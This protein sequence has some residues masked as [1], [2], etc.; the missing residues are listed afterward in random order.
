MKRPSPTAPAAPPVPGAAVDRAAPKAR[1]DAC[2]RTGLEPGAPGSLSAGPVPRPRA[3]AVRNRE[4]ILAAA[5][6][7]FV[8]FG[9]AAA[10][11]EVAR[12]A[13]IGN[14]TVYRHF[15]DRSSLVHHVVLYVMGRVGAEAEAALA[16]EPDAFAALRR[17]THTAADERIGALCTM[18][19]GDFDREHPELL[20]ARSALEDRVVALL[21]AGQDAGLVR[22]DIGV[23]DLMVALSQLSRPLPGVACLD[24]DRFVHR[25]LQLFLDGLQ[26][27]ARSE[28]PGSAATFEDLRA[29]TM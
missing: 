23:G 4:R 8:E 2:S 1:T 27:P 29:K 3:D 21:T 24:A 10:F 20:A 22:A 16:E 7:A 28:L 6:E 25:H 9:S 17:F 14:A 11:D 15:P 18:L 12:R 26:A 13:G 19:G 5:R